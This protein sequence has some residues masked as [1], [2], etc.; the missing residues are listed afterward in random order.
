M[1]KITKKTTINEIN[2]YITRGIANGKKVIEIMKEGNFLHNIYHGN[3]IDL[4]HDISLTYGKEIINII[5]NNGNN[6][7]HLS[8]PIDIVNTNHLISYG[9]RLDIK[10]N[11]GTTPFHMICANYNSSALEYIL[12]TIDNIKMMLSLRDIKGNT[13]LHAAI[14]AENVDIIKSLLKYRPNL[15]ITNDN[16]DNVLFSAVRR[17]NTKIVEL[18]LSTNYKF[19]HIHRD[20]I[21]ITDLAMVDSNSQILK[22]LEKYKMPTYITDDQ[23]H[24][25]HKCNICDSLLINPT[26]LNCKHKY[27]MSCFL[28]GNNDTS[29]DKLLCPFR[30]ASDITRSTVKIDTSLAELIAKKYPKD[31]IQHRY[32]LNNIT[33]AHMVLSKLDTVSD[34]L[35]VT[36]YRGGLEFYI[37]YINKNIKITVKTGIWL[38][39][40]MTVQNNIMKLLLD[41]N[42]PT[43]KLG[44]GSLYLGHDNMIYNDID[45]P[46]TY[47][48]T[49]VVEKL[50]DSIILP[51]QTLIASINTFSSVVPININLQI[52]Q[53]IESE[54]LR[55]PKLVD[56]LEDIHNIKFSGVDLKDVNMSNIT[57][58]IDINISP[59]NSFVELS[60]VIGRVDINHIHTYKYLL[61]YRSSTMEKVHNARISVDKQTG[62]VSFISI[63]IYALSDINIIN[64]QYSYIEEVSS[65][66]QQAIRVNCKQ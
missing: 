49:N 24:N 7:L 52:L 55:K 36:L 23:I 22:L 47:L 19:N 39:N 9:V 12:N 42:N 28:L 15:S 33:K 31:I 34:N 17:Q 13:P 59:D 2:S 44:V 30:C 51:I 48:N 57:K 46:I 40:I 32:N 10:N 54:F 43:G 16:G 21:T 5:D 18:L 25:E 11:L 53:D 8:I 14:K 4:I 38:P 45:L 37:R 26:K 27:C 20:K 56:V 61:S 62:A 1:I 50:L 6:L 41:A 66:L 58:T 65:T 60:K 35:G 29:T 64:E 63:I 3:R